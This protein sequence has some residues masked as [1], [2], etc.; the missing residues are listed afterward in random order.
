[1]ALFQGEEID[2]IG[3]VDDSWNS[4]DGMCHWYTP[5]KLTIVFNVINQQRRVVKISN[6]I[7]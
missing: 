1:M 4:K 6:D 3:A 7:L 5:T 2:I